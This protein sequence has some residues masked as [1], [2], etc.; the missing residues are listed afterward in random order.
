MNNFMK[1]KKLWQRLGA[2]LLMTAVLAGS[3]PVNGYVA[4]AEAVVESSEAELI[5]E[6]ILPEIPVTAS[7]MEPLLTLCVG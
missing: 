6:E 2:L 3:I 4:E 5:Q 1:K 7:L